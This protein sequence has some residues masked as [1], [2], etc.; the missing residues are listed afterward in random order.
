MVVRIEKRKYIQKKKKLH[1]FAKKV[2]ILQRFC[3]FM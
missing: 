1:S 3:V 2:L